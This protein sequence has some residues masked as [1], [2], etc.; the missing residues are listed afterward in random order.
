[1]N[2]P[3]ALISMVDEH[4]SPALIKKR[5]EKAYALFGERVKYVGPDCGLGLWP[6]IDAAK[7]LLANTVTA[8]SNFTR[9]SNL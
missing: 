4:E 5:L 7:K 3:K 6:T 2:N 9:G 1:M 8:T